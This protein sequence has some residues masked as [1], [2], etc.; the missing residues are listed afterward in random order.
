MMFFAIHQSINDHREAN[1]EGVELGVGGSEDWKM[2]QGV[3]R[4]MDGF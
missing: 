1:N 2:R 3:Y 4:P